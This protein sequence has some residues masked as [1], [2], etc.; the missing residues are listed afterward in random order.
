MQ[1]SR[2]HPRAG[3][4]WLTDFGDPFPHEPA[5]KRPAVIIGPRTNRTTSLPFVFAV[6]ITTTLRKSVCH[7]EIYPNAENGL[8]IL[9]AAQTELMR[10]ISRERCVEQM[11]IIDTDGWNAIRESVQAL[12]NY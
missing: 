2:R 1:S 10:S 6:P 7:V 12:L 5:G 8:K 11:G 4:I 9:S 3:E